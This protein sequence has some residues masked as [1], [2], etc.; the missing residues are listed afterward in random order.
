MFYT[1]LCSWSHS[2]KIVGRE[3]QDPVG[4]W[5]PRLAGSWVS[6]NSVS[7]VSSAAWYQPTLFLYWNLDWTEA[8]GTQLLCF[9]HKFSSSIPNCHVCCYIS[10]LDFLFCCSKKYQLYA[11][12]CSVKVSA[13]HWHSSEFSHRVEV[14]HPEDA[15]QDEGRYTESP[16]N[17]E[18][19]KCCLWVLC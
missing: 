1:N 4:V 7:L 14:L 13:R 10:Y 11:H 3:L 2:A 5:F 6:G 8:E 9:L 17:P 12:L 15:I 18:L 16:R 19:V